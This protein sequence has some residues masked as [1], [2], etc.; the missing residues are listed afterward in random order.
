MGNGQARS[1]QVPKIA[2]SIT[3]LVQGLG[4][5]K[6]KLYA[7]LKQGRLRCIRIDGRTLVTAQDLEAFIDSLRAA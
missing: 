1:N 6:T 4:I 5:G 2:Y 3:D 7:L